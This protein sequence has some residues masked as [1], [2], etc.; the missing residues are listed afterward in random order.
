MPP[1]VGGTLGLFVC[2]RAACYSNESQAMRVKK[3]PPN[4]AESPFCRGFDFPFACV[5]AAAF[6]LGFLSLYLS[7]SVRQIIPL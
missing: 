1:W 5:S 3:L 2:F 6:T 7:L 4:N